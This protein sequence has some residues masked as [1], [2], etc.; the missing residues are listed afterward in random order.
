MDELL[1]GEVARRAGVN[2]SAVRYYEGLG[3]LPA[4]RRVNGR[5]RY[6]P[7]VVQRLTLILFARRVG[8]SLAEIGRLLGERRAGEARFDGWQEAASGKL[9]EIDAW[10][11]RAQETKAVLEKGRD[12]ACTSP[13][14]CVVM[15]RS[16]WQK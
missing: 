3:L 2:P 1:I 10:I 8:F 9:A 13:D 12:C 4:P 7:M 15:D 16:W 11:R 5:R 14:E 6:D